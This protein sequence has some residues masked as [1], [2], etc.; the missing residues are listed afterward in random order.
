MLSFRFI[1]IFGVS[2]FR[3]K[4]NMLNIICIEIFVTLLTTVQADSHRLLIEYEHKPVEPR[5]TERRPFKIIR[6]I[7]PRE[8]IQTDQAYDIEENEG[9]SV[10]QSKVVLLHGHRNAKRRRII[11]RQP[12][13]IENSE[14]SRRIVV[15]QPVLVEGNGEPKKVIMKQPVIVE[16]NGEAGKV[17]VQQPAVVEDSD[18]EEPKSQKIL[19]APETVVYAYPPAENTVDVKDVVYHYGKKLHDTLHSALHGYMRLAQK[20]L[21]IL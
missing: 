10:R 2:R 20:V 16:D 7:V 6:Q 3:S 12:T 5:T 17:I 8:I 15:R 19:V 18:S 9:T 13:A 11:V 4:C 21:G 1:E 14:E